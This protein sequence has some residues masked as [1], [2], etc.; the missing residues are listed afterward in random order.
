MLF[1]DKEGRLWPEEEVQKL[2]LNEIGE[3]ELRVCLLLDKKI[4]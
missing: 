1:E 3:L 2:D 4:F